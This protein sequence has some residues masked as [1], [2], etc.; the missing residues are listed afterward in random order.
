MDNR[1]RN[2]KAEYELKKQQLNLVTDALTQAYRG[3][4]SSTDPTVTECC[5]FEINSLR[6]RRNSILRDM[7]SIDQERST[8]GNYF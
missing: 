4:N 3:F 1:K 7:H 2:L 5:I 8:H 6:S